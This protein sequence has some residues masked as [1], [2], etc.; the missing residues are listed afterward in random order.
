MTGKA[1]TAPFP[2]PGKSAA[3]VEAKN[4]Y[5]RP[6]GMVRHP[7]APIEA[8][9]SERLVCL[10]FPWYKLVICAREISTA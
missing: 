7:P 10:G 2:N 4:L 8:R 1:N 3:P 9:T 6:D 5:F